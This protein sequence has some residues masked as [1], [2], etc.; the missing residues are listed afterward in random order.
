MGDLREVDLGK[1]TGEGVVP[2]VG[3]LRGDLLKGRGSCGSSEDL[4]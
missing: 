3:E 1:G 2:S 4:C